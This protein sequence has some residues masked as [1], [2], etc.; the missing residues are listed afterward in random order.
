DDAEDGG[1]GAD[2]ECQ[3]D[4]RDGREARL[5]A[6]HPYAEDDIL[7]ERVPHRDSSWRF[8]ADWRKRAIAAEALPGERRRELQRV[9]PDDDPGQRGRGP[10]S[11][12]RTV[13]VRPP[14]N[15]LLEQVAGDRI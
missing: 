15:V 14:R 4:E 10:V 11:V 1:V 8:V 3:R 13:E 5:A 6:Q 7:R 9:T 12:V 2:A